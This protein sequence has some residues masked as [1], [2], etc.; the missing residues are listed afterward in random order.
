MNR[1]HSLLLSLSLW[2]LIYYLSLYV[3]P[4]LAP[5]R[6]LRQSLTWLGSGD[7]TQTFFLVFSL[8]AM[9]IIG[10]GDLRRFGFKG[11]RLSQLAK[12]VL[13][14]IACQV[15]LFVIAMIAMSVFGGP[16][17]EMSGASGPPPVD[18]PGPGPDEMSGPM[19]K[20][21]LSTILSVWIYASIIEEVFYRGLCQSLLAKYQG[22]TFPLFRARISLPVA[23]FAL[24]FGLGHL[25]LLSMF[26]GM[27]LVLI[28]VSCI[29]L[30][31]IAG[32]YREKTG[33]LI[34]AIVVHSTANIVGAVFPMLVMSLMN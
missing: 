24:L 9:L 15:A 4:D 21:F 14:T 22:I 26:G 6:A 34:P 18:G 31:L 29:V 16:G 7:L 13:I 11:V 19:G 20:G 33:S 10:K 25:C 8:A 27:F 1:K 3:L 23:V 5:L 28:I 32:Y 17:G 12:P 2:A 30:G